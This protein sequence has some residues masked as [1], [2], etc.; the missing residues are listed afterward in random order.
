VEIQL[1]DKK[2]LTGEESGIERPINKK[3]V[4]R[5]QKCHTIKAQIITD[6]L[7]GEITCVAHT[8]GSTHGF[9]LYQTSIG[10][11]IPGDI[12][13]R[14]DSGYQGI[15]KFNANSETPKRKPKGGE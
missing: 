13:P 3:R 8:V 14:G 4:F 10:S 7:S 12:P 5:R 11:G 2:E 1:P 9:R 6:A 15:L